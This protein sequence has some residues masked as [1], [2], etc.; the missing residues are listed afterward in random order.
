[1]L[2]G[3]IS[4]DVECDSIGFKRNYIDIYS[5][6]WGP[7]DDGKTIDGPGSC[8]KTALKEGARKVSFTMLICQLMSDARLLS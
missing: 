4:D 1:M 8:T 3:R 2:D 7:D 6:S 5:M